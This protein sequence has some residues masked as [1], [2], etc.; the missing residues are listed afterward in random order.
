MALSVSLNT[1]PDSVRASAVR[2]LHLLESSKNSLSFFRRPLLTTYTYEVGGWQDTYSLLRATGRNKDFPFTAS[3][4]QPARARI[5]F[6]GSQQEISHASLLYFPHNEN[7]FSFFLQCRTSY[8]GGERARKG[9]RRE[10]WA[11][12]SRPHAATA[13]AVTLRRFSKRF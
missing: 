12:F 1:R 8:K 7:R 13:G 3:A 9:R 6:K 5:P 2:R 4:G 10:K 11:P